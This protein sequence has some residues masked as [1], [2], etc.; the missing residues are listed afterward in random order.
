MDSARK[1]LELLNINYSLYPVEVDDILQCPA[2]TYAL[3]SNLKKQLCLFL[4]DVKMPKEFCSNIGGRVNI[5]DKKISG[6]KSHDC[7]ILLQY[8]IP[9]ATRALLPDDVYDALVHLSRFFRLLCQKSLNRD[10]LEE[11]QDD[12]VLTLCKLEKIFP[13][14]FFDIMVHLPLHLAIEA[15]LGGSI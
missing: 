5:I 10:E 9:L 4:K 15:L 13:H 11:L 2:A 14:S 12:I 7:H 1:D 8:L 3:S 6:L